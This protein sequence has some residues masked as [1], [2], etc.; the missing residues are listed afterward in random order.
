MFCGVESL[1][2]D[3]SGGRQTSLLIKDSFA[4]ASDDDSRRNY[5]QYLCNKERRSLPS[6]LF[7]GDPS[8]VAVTRRRFTK[9]HTPSV[10][11]LAK[12]FCAAGKLCWVFIPGN[13]CDLQRLRYRG[14]DM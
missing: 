4:S 12:S 13:R 2:L 7:F 9:I 11:S 10:P 1:F 6:N 3:S 5:W 8:Q 14:I